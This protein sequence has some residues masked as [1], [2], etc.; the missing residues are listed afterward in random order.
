MID[1]ET[2][3]KLRRAEARRHGDRLRGTPQPR[4][5]ARHDALQLVGTLVD[6]EWSGRENRRLTR[7]LKLA[8]R[9]DACLE[10]VRC[11]P[12]RG[13][14][15]VI[16]RCSAAAPIRPAPAAGNVR[17]LGVWL[18]RRP[19]AFREP[20]KGERGNA[21]LNVREDEPGP[22]GEQKIVPALRERRAGR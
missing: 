4:S 6:R 3:R 2:L 5:A 13:L 22:A 17:R 1:H 12:G 21:G 8:N 16:V 9:K 20:L 7:L 10:D 14:K 19:E 18:T 11:E 15:N